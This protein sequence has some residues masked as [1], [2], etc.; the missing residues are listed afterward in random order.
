MVFFP[1][2]LKVHVIWL[3]KHFI[4]E[5]SKC[6]VILK[7]LVLRQFQFCPKVALKYLLHILHLCVAYS[8][9]APLSGKSIFIRKKRESGKVANFAS[10]RTCLYPLQALLVLKSKVSYGKGDLSLTPTHAR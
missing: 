10:R 8:I 6:L 1:A 2:R 3:F 9:I 4:S 7:L 5:Q